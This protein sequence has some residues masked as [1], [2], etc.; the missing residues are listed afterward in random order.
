MMLNSEIMTNLTELSLVGISKKFGETL[1]VDN[2]SL[3]VKKGVFFTLLGPSGCGKTT[4]LRIIAGLLKVDHGEIYIKGSRV[5]DTAPYLRNIGM[6]FQ[7]YALFPYMS[8]YDNIA[9]GL[10]VRHFPK[11]KIAPLVEE[12][13]GNTNLS[14]LE[15]RLPNE[16]SGGQQQRVALARA[17]VIKPNVL[18][19]DEP[20]SNLDLKVRMM[21]RR[22]IKTLTKRLNTTTIN[23]THDQGEALSMSD[24]VGVMYEGRVVQVGTPAEIYERPTTQFVANFIG[25]TNFLEAS[26]ADLE[27]DFV[28]LKVL[29][30]LVYAKRDAE[31]DKTQKIGEKVLLSVRPEKITMSKHKPE[32]KNVFQG[33]IEDLDYFGSF[34]RYTVK[35]AEVRLSCESNSEYCDSVRR[36]DEVYVCFNPEDC[37]LSQV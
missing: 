37:F 25:E 24:M 32:S 14:G 35:I 12:V 8:V 22:E 29:D 9:F 34:T 18:L 28:R 20:L 11:E 16:L 19:L 31:S 23:V 3:E 30:L 10:R 13:L 5:T 27:R 15:N 21:M 36:G 7:N 6:V 1:A 17:I 2:V 33:R 4:I 26:I